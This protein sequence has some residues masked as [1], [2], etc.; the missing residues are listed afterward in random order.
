MLSSFEQTLRREDTVQELDTIH[1]END[2]KPDHETPAAETVVL[3]EA[4][5]R[6]VKLGRK[7]EVADTAGWWG[8]WKTN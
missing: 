6:K 1:R 2:G 4:E 3:E 8:A 5:P 7:V